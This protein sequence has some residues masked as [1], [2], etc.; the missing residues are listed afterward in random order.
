MT[1]PTETTREFDPELF[2]FLADLK[3]HNDRDWFAANKQRYEAH[4]LEPALAFIED[5]GLRLHQI[6]PHFRA[7]T[8]KT[9]GSLFRIYRD[10]R[11]SKD[12]TPYKTNTGMHFR[13]AQAKDAHAPGFY[14]HLAP[15][16]VFGGAG[17]WHPDTKTATKIREAIV[18]DPDRWR[19]ATRTKP[20]TERLDLGGHDNRLKRVPS[21]FD[22][23][24]EFADDLRRRDYFGWAALSEEMAT[25]PGFLDEYTRICEAAAPLVKFICDALKLEF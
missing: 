15:G 19:A 2:Q 13:H 3:E 12:K 4:V 14:L 20:F 24:H 8:R 11:F 5:F 16:Q 9:G 18:A 1:A 10:T 17:I 7:D 23:G 21:G 25:T 6:S 22:S